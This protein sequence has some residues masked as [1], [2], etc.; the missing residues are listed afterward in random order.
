VIRGALAA[1]PGP[2]RPA[3]RYEGSNRYYRGRV[4]AALREAHG[5]GA[6]LRELRESLDDVGGE[7]QVAEALESLRKDGLVVVEDEAAG[8]GPT[9][10]EE[11][12]A[13]GRARYGTDAMGGLDGPVRVRLPDGSWDA[14]GGGRLHLRHLAGQRQPVPQDAPRDG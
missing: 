2:E 1:A 14:P 11:V 9:G 3:P 13:E 10:A 12:V 7:M 8:G 4:L 5:E 6:T